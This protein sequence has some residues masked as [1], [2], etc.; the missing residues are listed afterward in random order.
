M[1]LFL[2]HAYKKKTW[3]HQI[4]ENIYTPVYRLSILKV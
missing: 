2:M 3:T 4:Q 1:Y